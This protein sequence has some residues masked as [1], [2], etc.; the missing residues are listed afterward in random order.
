MVFDT[1]GALSGNVWRICF[2]IKSISHAI[3]HIGIAVSDPETAN[4]P[5]HLI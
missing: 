3:D 5:G 1:A 4:K 2:K